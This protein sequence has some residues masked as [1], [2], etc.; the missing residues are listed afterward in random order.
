MNQLILLLIL[1]RI[2]SGISDAVYR[3]GAGVYHHQHVAGR[4]GAAIT[5]TGGNAGHGRRAARAVGP[6]SADLAALF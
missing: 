5:G 3:L 2:G 6:E 4:C 1:R